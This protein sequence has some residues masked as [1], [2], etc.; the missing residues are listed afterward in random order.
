[1]LCGQNGGGENVNI[2]LILL[3]K[4]AELGGNKCLAETARHVTIQPQTHKNN[5]IPL[6]SMPLVQFLPVTVDEDRG[7]CHCY[8]FCGKL[9]LGFRSSF[10][11]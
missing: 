5:L 8:R 6:V 10:Q 3:K 2:D 4:R 11:R 7:S 1:M 9:M